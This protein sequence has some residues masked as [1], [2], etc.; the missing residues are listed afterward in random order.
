MADSHG[1]ADVSQVGIYLAANFDGADATNACLA[2]YDR[3]TNRLFLAGNAATD[4]S[5]GVLN[6]G[7]PLGNGRCRLSLRDSRVSV[8]GDR[9]TVQFAITFDGSFRGS[10]LV[11]AYA[12][13]FGNSR[14]TGWKEVGSWTVTPDAVP[15]ADPARAAVAAAAGVDPNDLATKQLFKPVT[16][17]DKFVTA[18]A[19]VTALT[20]QSGQLRFLLAGGR[21]VAVV[22][23]VT[24]QD[25]QSG[26]WVPNAPVLSETNNGWRMDG[27]YNDLIIRKQGLDKHVITQTYT[28]F[29]SKHDSVLTLTVPSLVYDKN[30]T[31]H[32]VQDGLTWN[33]AADDGAAFDLSASAAK[34]TGPKKY[35]FAVSSSEPLSVNQNGNL[36]GDG[37]VILSRA[38]MI[39]KSGKRVQ[40]SAW[41]YSSKDGASFVCDDTGF[42]D[43]QLP[44]RIDPS[45]QSLTDGGTFGA[46]WQCVDGDGCSGNSSDV[47]F[48][49]ANM[50][51]PGAYSVNTSC[52]YDV[53]DSSFFGAD[54]VACSADS[55]N[56]AGT[57]NVNIH[58]VSGDGPSACCTAGQSWAEVTN[59]TLTVTWYNPVSVTVS[60]S[61]ITVPAGQPCCGYYNSLLNASVDSP[62]TA[63][64]WT[65]SPGSVGSFSYAGPTSVWYVPPAAVDA[66]TTITAIATSVA[67]PSKSGS[68]SVTIVPGL[69]TVSVAPSSA[70]LYAGQT[71]QFSATVT[72]RLTTG[73][74]W[75]ISPAIGT[76]SA[77]GLYTAPSP[78]PSQQAVTVTAS[79]VLDSSKYA[80]AV[81][82]LAR[83]MPAGLLAWWPGDGNALDVVS[84]AA[85]TPLYSLTFGSGKVNQALTNWVQSQTPGSVSGARTLS[86][87]V[88]PPANSQSDIAIVTGGG[89]SFGLHPYGAQYS[90]FMNSVATGAS[91][92]PNVWTHVAMTYDGATI[93]L[94]VNGTLVQTS[95]GSL[96]DHGL[97]AYQVM[98][99]EIQVYNRALSQ[100]EIAQAMSPIAITISPASGRI[101]GGQQATFTA[102]VANTG[103]LSA[104]VTW[105]LGSGN[106]GSINAAGIY[107]APASVS[108]TQQ[109]TIVATSVADPSRAGTA[110]MTLSVPVAVSVDTNLAL[111]KTATQSSTY[112]N[113]VASKAVDGNTDGNYFDG[114]VTHTLDDPNAWWQVDLGA[115][116][117]ISSVVIWNR[118]DAVMERMSDYWVFVSNSPFATNDTPTT[119]QNR[120]GTW[121]SHQTSFP[122]PS[123]NISFNVTGRYVRVQLSSTNYLH[124]AEVQ[125]FGPNVLSPSQTTQ[126]TATVSNADNTAVTW[127]MASGPGAINAYGVYT[128]PYA[129]SGTTTAT[130]R[131]TSVAD[132]TKSATATVTINAW[133]TGAPYQYY[134]SD[135]M[136]A[137]NPA[138]WGLNGSATVSSAGLSASQMS[139]RVG[140]L[141][142]G[143]SGRDERL[144]SEG[145][146]TPD[147]SDRLRVSSPTRCWRGPARTPCWG[148]TKAAGR[149]GDVL[150]LYDVRPLV[151][152]RRV[153][154]EHVSVEDGERVGDGA[155][156]VPVPSATTE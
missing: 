11:Y 17:Y 124:M 77:S 46:G 126:L 64:T 41:A 107:Q 18:N 116:A 133:G 128:S 105:S 24:H 115:A 5:S 78:V 140:D 6:E 137:A 74:N 68:A 129:V 29:A 87:W 4:W 19:G 53:V 13:S 118:T 71:R 3:S 57:T 10:K 98:W 134:V 155:V 58:M 16:P 101:Y 14:N 76:I 145:D 39:P 85:A 55:L 132:P 144:R 70:L 82:Q 62:N 95:G 106:P 135:P 127:A 113:N 40:C 30:L 45:S 125:V 50:L 123:S 52:G 80:T 88:N 96:A 93:R 103:T 89:D 48:N 112:G 54:G 149:T 44:Y 65:T 97:N 8:S 79:S 28:D 91:V 27:T 9:V 56:N 99:D 37:N 120:T 119:L 100:A 146:G 148:R 81:V 153:C 141:A 75:S 142:S 147:E 102:T 12:N 38:V 59:V 121:S 36:V 84:G 60:P 47:H 31:F 63:A 32:F 72:N 69:L 21:K 61:A 110:S 73:V 49:T 22:G 154:R 150:R 111:G 86:A 131:A 122:N 34:R 104:G 156:A 83:P 51:P 152:H 66:T 94:D 33:L 43:N 23:A 42:K 138:L 130:V 25:K 108:S 20:H 7:E 151:V 1:G 114:S 35:T 67:D 90:L 139:A 136:T 117:S 143:D 15:A 92:T 26:A 2:Y 109:I